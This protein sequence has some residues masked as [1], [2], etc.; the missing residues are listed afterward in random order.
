MT[1]KKVLHNKV[2]EEQMVNSI[3]SPTISNNDAEP[4][5]YDIDQ[6]TDWKKIVNVIEDNFTK[7]DDAL[8]DL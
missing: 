6:P 5:P 2:T 4:L 8:V 1:P 7:I 3:E